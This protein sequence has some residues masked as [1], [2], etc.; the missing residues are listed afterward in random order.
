MGIFKK[1][2]LLKNNIKVLRERNED[3]YKRDIEHQ[4]KFQKEIKKKNEIIAKLRIALIDTRGFLEQETQAK[5]ELLKER[6]K[7]RK[8]ITKLGGNWKDGK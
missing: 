1:Y 4:A 3:L 8:M 7:L 5:E 2:D 6:T